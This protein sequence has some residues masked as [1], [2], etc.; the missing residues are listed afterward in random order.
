MAPLKFT[1]T[2]VCS[3]K[4]LSTVWGRLPY[5]KV[6]AFVKPLISVNRFFFA[7]CR[8]LQFFRPFFLCPHYPL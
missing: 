8:L 3:R 1:V 6:L 5:K 4:G 2:H 7:N